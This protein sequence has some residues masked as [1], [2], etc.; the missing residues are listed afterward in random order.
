MCPQCAVVYC[1]RTIQKEVKPKNYLLMTIC[2]LLH[3]RMSSC[4]LWLYESYLDVRI[5]AFLKH[6]CAYRTFL[7]IYLKEIDNNLLS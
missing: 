5:I 2:T 3:G 4:T 6:I 7:Y 1:Q